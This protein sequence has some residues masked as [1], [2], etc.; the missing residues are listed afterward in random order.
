MARA[1]ERNYAAAVAKKLLG[2]FNLGDAIKYCGC[3]GLCTAVK[4]V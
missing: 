3:S 1:N 4:A 2:D